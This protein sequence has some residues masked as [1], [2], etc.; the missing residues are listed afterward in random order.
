M[1]LGMGLGRQAC[2]RGALVSLL[3][4]V[5]GCVTTPAPS[6]PRPAL[7]LPAEIAARYALPA[8]VHEDYLVPT[9]SDRR[10][11]RGRLRCGD[12]RP[13]FHLL[14]PASGGPAPFVLC[15][16][17]LAGGRDL[18]WLV[19]EYLNS[20][21]FVVAFGERV[22]S[23][24]KPH[25]DVDA[26]ENLFRRSLLHNRAILAWARQQEFASPDQVGVLGISTGGIMAGTLLALEPAVRGGVLILA[27]GDLPD[28]LMRSSESRIRAWR[29]ARQAEDGL[30]TEQLEAALRAGLHSDP[31]RAARY[32]G[33]DKVLM[34]TASWD[35]VVPAR[36]SDY[37]WEALGKPER[38]KLLLLSHYSSILDVVLP[39][40]VILGRAAEF[41]RGRLTGVSTNTD[42]DPGV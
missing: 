18:M 11:F 7:P 4:S 16:P 31:A 26:L 19:A 40:Q 9:A 25:Q 5:T 29:A 35:T 3:V 24:M 12:E 32:V 23:A 33:T 2:S 41:L 14:L 6:D 20:R 34:V 8:E 36:N 10:V 30:D 22:E 15:L 27:G 38:L 21:G 37:L 39:T 1:G 13:D 17:I 42:R 28:L